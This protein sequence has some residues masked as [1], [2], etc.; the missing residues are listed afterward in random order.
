MLPPV[1]DAVL[2]TNPL[3][4]ALHSNL[5][6]NLLNLNGST[7][8]HPAQKERDSVKEALRKSYINASK[9][10]LLRSALRNLDLSPSTF[11][12]TT[13][14]T[15]TETTATKSRVQP[16]QLPSNLIELVILLS[17]RVSSFTPN[18]SSA[19]RLLENSPQWM[20][21]PV[22]LPQ[23]GALISSHL[24]TQAVGLC[25]MASPNTNASFLHRLIPK[26]VPT[27]QS[28]QD[29][30]EDQRRELNR[31]RVELA[32]KVKVL[33][34]L[35][36]L[37]STLVILHLEQTV[38][39]SV[40][41]ELRTKAELLGLTAQKLELEAKEKYLRCEREVYSA[42]VKNALSEYM[43]SL[44]YTGERLVERKKEAQKILLEYGVGRPDNEKEK[45]MRTIAKKYAELQTELRE[46]GRDI[47][48]LK[49]K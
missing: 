34:S 39:G 22:H 27:I 38:H 43:A 8:V 33:L 26:L 23:I 31:R 13:A 35:Y 20:S 1:D 25:R 10:Y 16:K 12:P 29:E 32:S 3:F 24:Q 9:G 15:T 5:T 30:I 41:R 18:S 46:V 47:D 45:I 37:A 6:K 42:P 2:Q 11:H 17:E 40:A 7:K 19:C 49:G 21:L 4:A 48:R 14:T 28:R 36:H 44:Q